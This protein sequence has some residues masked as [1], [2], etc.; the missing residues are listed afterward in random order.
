MDEKKLKALAAELAKGLKTEADLNQFSRML[1]KLTVET[2][3]NAELTNHLGHEKNAPKTGTNTRNGYSSKTL[4]CDDGEI[5]LN[6]PRDRENT[7]E[8]QLIKKNQ[9]RIT[10]MD[11]QILSLYAKGMTTREIVDTFKEMYD[12]DVS[13]ALISKV[14]DAVKEQVTEWQ[15]RQLDA[16]YPIVYMDCIVVKVRQNGSVINKA[17]FLALGINTEGR[18]ELLGMWLAE[19]E[20]A[21]FWLNVLTELKNRGLQDI[22]IAC[23]DGLKGFPD[24][25]NSV[26]PQTHIQL[27]IIHMVRNSLK[28]V[29][30]KDYKAVTGGLK[31]VYQAPTEAA[32]L[33]A[34]D[35]FAE[36]WDEK[37]PQISKSWRAHWENLNTFFGYPPD[38]RKA[39]YTTNA[40][41]SL[42]SVIRAAIK[43]RKVFPTDD[44]VRKVVYLAIQ[45]A[46]K[47]WS[48]PIQN[49]RLAMSRFIIEFGD[50]LS[51]HL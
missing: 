9:T 17:V 26:Y 38:I 33:M 28:Y 35:A 36:E 4:L 44:S 13:L 23:V 24:A 3:L 7:F 15:N 49:W 29:A 34:L 41:E 43:K 6:T 42:N 8:P 47:K 48:M 12:A 39:I 1:T 5:E 37:Y 32:A 20:G 25:I 21:K 18:K 11:S 22:L 50:R 31:A 14:T 2:A 19:N 51:D 10:Q 46:S 45:A 27:C 40:I 30:W 16:L